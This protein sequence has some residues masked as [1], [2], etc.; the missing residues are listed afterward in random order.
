M[1]GECRGRRACAAAVR[2]ARTGAP[3]RLAIAEPQTTRVLAVDAASDCV[4][5]VTL[6]PDGAVRVLDAQSG[7]E[8]LCPPDAGE[9]SAAEFSRD[10]RVILTESADNPVA[11]GMRVMGG[12]SRRFR[13]SSRSC[14]PA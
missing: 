10:G 13:T 5:A 1:A 11:S 14:L 2:D 3:P 9:V 12:C 7:V 8:T 6:G 4:R